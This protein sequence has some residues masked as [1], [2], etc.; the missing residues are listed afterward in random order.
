MHQD[1]YGPIKQA[2]EAFPAG[3]SVALTEKDATAGSDN[4][5]EEDIGC[6]LCM[7]C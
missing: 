2:A 6:Q 7:A 1:V 3:F 4:A 5:C